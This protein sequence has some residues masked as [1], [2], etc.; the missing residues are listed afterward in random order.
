MTLN[1]VAFKSLPY[2][3]T[4]LHATLNPFLYPKRNKK[5][6]DRVKNT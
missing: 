5:T 3:G 6:L 4:T 1:P 2:A